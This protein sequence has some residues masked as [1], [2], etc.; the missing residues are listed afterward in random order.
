M[1]KILLLLI[2]TIFSLHTVQ[3]QESSLD[4]TKK[5]LADGFENVRVSKK[6]NTTFVTLEDCHYRD[7]SYGLAQAL[8]TIS[9]SVEIDDT[10]STNSSDTIVLI[11]LENQVPKMTINAIHA[12]KE[13]E[14]DCQYGGTLPRNLARIK[15]EGRS[16]FKADFVFYP[17]VELSN[18]RYDRLWSLAFW[19][20]PALQMQLWKGSLLTAQVRL[21]IWEDYVGEDYDKVEPGFITLSQRIISSQHFDASATV[22]LLGHHRNGMDVN[23]TWH[24]NQR[25]DL[26]LQAGYTGPWTMNDHF[27]ICKWDKLEMLAHLNY[28]EPHTNLQLEVLAG[29]FLYEDR[30]VRVDLH[31]H[32]RDYAIGIY[33]SAT[34]W[35][36]HFGFEFSVPIGPRKL[37]KHRNVRLRL[38]NTFAFNFNDNSNVK[39]GKNSNNVAQTY[40]IAPDENHSAHYWQPEFLKIYLSKILNNAL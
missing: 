32:Y 31:R 7:I 19:I 12:G 5:L 20:S 8:M 39:K 17:E 35:G 14:I 37:G 33:G 11:A 27:K 28:F 36:S 29:Q 23:G 16:A 3:S 1:K 15:P 25:L 13:W 26:G 18:N 30:G 21:P 38:P 2:S 24:V 40:R 9:P 34:D 22:G 4:I 6:E 10:I